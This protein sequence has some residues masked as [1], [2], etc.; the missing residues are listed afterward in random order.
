MVI[1]FEKPSCYLRSMT[2]K[3]PKSFELTIPSR[4]EEM[5]AVHDLIDRLASVRAWNE[6]E[7]L[8]DGKIGLGQKESTNLTW[9]EYFAAGA[10]T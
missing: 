4:L 10:R 1:D 5:E 6:D 3:A 8:R 2:L 9:C 7:A